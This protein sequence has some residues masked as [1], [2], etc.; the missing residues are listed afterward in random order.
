[1]WKI[2]DIDANQKTSEQNIWI[3][4]AYVF[5]IKILSVYVLHSFQ[6]FFYQ[7]TSASKVHRMG[8]GVYSG[9]A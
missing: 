5:P 2:C 6:Y 1:M 9:R 8:T 3:F 4:H 7:G